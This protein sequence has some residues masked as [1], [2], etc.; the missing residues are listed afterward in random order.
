MKK[1]TRLL[2]LLL[3]VILCL[4][5]LPVSAAASSGWQ[6]IGDDW[7]YVENGAAVTGWKEIGGKT[8]YLDP[9]KG[10]TMYV[11]WLEYP[12]GSNDWYY[13]NSSGAMAVNQ[14][15]K[16]TYQS[17]TI[18][19][20]Q[21]SDGKGAMGWNKIGGYWYYF[22]PDAEGVMVS[23]DF[24][25]D[26]DGYVYH[27]G[28][29]GRMD[30]NKW[31]ALYYYDQDS[32][33]VKGWYYFESSGRAAQGWRKLGGVW[34]YFNP[35]SGGEMAVKGLWDIRGRLYW[36]NDNG[37][38]YTGW[39][40]VPLYDDDGYYR[41][42]FWLYFTSNGAAQGWKQIGGKWYFFDKYDHCRMKT[43]GTLIG[44]KEYWFNDDGSLFT[45]WKKVHNMYYGDVWEYFTENG[46]VENSWKKIDGKWYYFTANMMTTGGPHDIGGKQYFFSDSGVMQTGWKKID[47]SWWYFTSSGAAKKDGWLKIGGTWYHFEDYV[48]TNP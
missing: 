27:L 28:S 5:V 39:K 12:S 47:G 17:D 10:G 19:Y 48:C 14:W 43:G 22:D 24:L 33:L 32:N 35:Y 16:E 1:T 38:L 4:S 20:Y 46:A 13:F 2:S 42:D 37:S 26:D 11:G 15:V 21:G 34:Y 30:T 25:F 45:G 8:Y 44:G 18:W 6:K 36:F 7:Y 3:V 23:D 9:S 31:V 41:G 29:S 40:K